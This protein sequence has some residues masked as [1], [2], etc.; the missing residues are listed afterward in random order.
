MK[1]VLVT[2]EHRGVFCGDVPEDQDLN[3]RT[4]ALKNARMALRWGT[5]KGVMQLA[6]T[7]P[8]SES[9]IGAAA[10]ID[11]LHDITA[12]FAVTDEAA[13]AWKQQ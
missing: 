13:A 4:M 11:S 1:S 6:A 8:T 12:V 3:A 10:D 5:T 9:V 7:G 2:T